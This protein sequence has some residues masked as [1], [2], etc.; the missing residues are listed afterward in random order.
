MQLYIDSANIEKI[1]P[2][3]ELG[4]VEGITTNPT[5]LSV[6]G[7]RPF[8]AIPALCAC[9]YPKPVSVE[10][11]EF[12]PDAVLKQAREIAAMAENIVVKIPCHAR[13]IPVI[14]TLLAAGTKLNITLIFT[15]SQ[16]YFMTKLGVQYISPFMGRLDDIGV[17]SHDTVQAIVS[18]IRQENAHTKVIAASIRTPKQFE[19]AIAAG[20]DI[21][22]VPPGFID[23]ALEHPLTEIG[24]AQFLTDWQ[25]TVR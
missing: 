13:Y 20:A 11:T 25:K 4:L 18:M 19:R 7:A 17:A 16:A 8:D 6:L 1:K 5:N 10:V 9:V 23:K 2:L 21:A 14:R 12:A 22:T 3:C 15:V 24:I